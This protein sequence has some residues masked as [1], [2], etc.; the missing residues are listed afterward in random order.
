ME[1]IG[2]AITIDELRGNARSSIGRA[3]GVA[4]ENKLCKRVMLS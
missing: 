4:S 2:F 1:V 3:E